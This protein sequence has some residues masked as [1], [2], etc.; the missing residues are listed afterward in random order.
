MGSH[1]LVNDELD[2]DGGQLG[3]RLLVH[4]ELD[5]DGQCYQIVNFDPFLS[6][7]CAR[8]ENGVSNFAA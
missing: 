2:D 1:L 8:V 3:P 5:D 7:D 6:L 4:D